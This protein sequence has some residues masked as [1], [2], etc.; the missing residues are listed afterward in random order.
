MISAVFDSMVLLQAATSRRGPA[1]GCFTFVGEGHV[2]LFISPAT[3]VEVRD[4]LHRPKVRTAFRQLTD[5]SVQDFL[6]HLLDVG[7]MIQDVPAVYRLLQDPDDEQCLNLAIANQPCCLVSWDTDLLPLMN[8]DEF[9]QAYPG[10]TVL[11]PVAFLKHV[12]TEVAKE[13]GYE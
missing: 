6:D 5:E 1:G 8:D 2:R 4:V 12:R 10:I 9:R 13:L 3:L 7:H 11:T